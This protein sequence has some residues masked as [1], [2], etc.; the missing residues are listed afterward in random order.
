M[1]RFIVLPVHR[2]N[3]PLTIM[4]LGH[5]L[6]LLVCTMQQLAVASQDPRCP[7]WYPRLNP[8]FPIQF[9]SQAFLWCLT[10]LARQLLIVP[11]SIALSIAGSCA[12]LPVPAELGICHATSCHPTIQS[13][14]WH[15]GTAAGCSFWVAACC[16]STAAV[17]RLLRGRER[18][19][20]AIQPSLRQRP[21]VARLLWVCHCSEPAC[22]HHG[23][24]PCSTCRPHSVYVQQQV[25]ICKSIH[26]MLAEA[27]QEAGEYTLVVPQDQFMS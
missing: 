3:L 23:D 20:L 19:V 7:W 8:T 13:G 5:A 25:P 15:T 4:L 24:G 12:F 26:L 21:P 18:H 14:W 6:K 27:V 16:S 2:Q 1:M 11:L 10:R 22:P 17:G 9:Q